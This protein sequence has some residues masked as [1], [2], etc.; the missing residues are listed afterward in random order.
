MYFHANPHEY[1][2]GGI[3]LTKKTKIARLAVL[4][5]SAAMA[6]GYVVSYKKNL[7]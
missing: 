3:T 7:I 5:L 6:A 4:M 1:K 2:T